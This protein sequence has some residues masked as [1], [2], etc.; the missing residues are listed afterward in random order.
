M[1]GNPMDKKRTSGGESKQE[2]VIDVTSSEG[3]RRKKRRSFKAH[4]DR[5]SGKFYYQDVDQPE[6]TTWTLPKDADLVHDKNAPA[7]VI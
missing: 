4:K 3:G 1:V 5:V 7:E 6:L 2:V